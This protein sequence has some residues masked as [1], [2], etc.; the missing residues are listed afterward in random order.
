MTFWFKFS[1]ASGQIGSKDQFHRKTPIYISYLVIQHGSYLWQIW[2]HVWVPM[3]YIS[4]KKHKQSMLIG[5]FPFY[6]GWE[7]FHL[8]WQ[9]SKW[10]YKCL[11]NVATG[12]FLE[13]Q[14][15]KY[16]YNKIGLS[17]DFSKMNDL[18]FRR[19]QSQFQKSKKFVKIFLI[20]SER[21]RKLTM[22]L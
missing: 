1:K 22:Q 14:T 10:I 16:F 18:E 7:L 11:P 9:H 13:H 12:H 8:T 2:E 21:L 3:I 4:S 15:A 6:N 17:N 5:L 20:F 19:S